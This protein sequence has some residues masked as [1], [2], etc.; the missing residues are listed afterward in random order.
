MLRVN[1]EPVDPALVDEAFMRLKA[2]AEALSQVSCCERDAEFRE[3]AENEVIDGILLAQEAE[4][5]IPPPGEDE[6]REAFGEAL[7]QWREH[8]ASWELLE[9]RRAALRDEIIADVRMR[10]F[11]ESLWADLPPAGDEELR[12][13]YQAHGSRFRQ[14]PAARVLHLVRFPGEDDPWEGFTGMVGLRQRAIA[15]E[16]FATLAAE[17][18]QKKDGEIDLGWI[19]MERP[20]NPFESMLFSL[21]E[22]EISPVFHY[23]QAWHLV[24]P[25]EVRPAVIPPF[26]ELEGTIRGEFEAGRRREKLRELAARLRETALIERD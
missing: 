19:E 7:R 8:G 12:A 25:V 20:L 18:T 17:H 5:T 10:H 15:G 23:E 4:K 22:G 6:V 26:D 9:A 16:D 21:R 2:E 14:A 1:G 24:L 13:W 3:Q 11:T